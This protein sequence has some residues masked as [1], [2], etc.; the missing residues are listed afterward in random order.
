[1]LD[2]HRPVEMP[3]LV[4]DEDERE[5][6]FVMETEFSA[7]KVVIP[8]GHLEDILGLNQLAVWVS[9]PLEV[10]SNEEEFVFRGTFLCLTESFWD[11]SQ[12]HSA[13]SG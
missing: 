2:A 12:F 4:H 1:M 10:N 5:R 9:D 13:Y 6:P 7:C 8:N 11:E 3:G